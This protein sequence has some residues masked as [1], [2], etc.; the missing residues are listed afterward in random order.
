[1]IGQSIGL[2][3]D[4]GPSRWT[5][6]I[7]DLLAAH[8]AR[9]TFFIVGTAAEAAPGLV[10]RIEAE[11]HEIGNHTWTH[12]ALARDCSD[13]QV[14]D[15]LDRTNELL[16]QILGTRPKLFRAPQ[17][18]CDDRVMG[19]AAELGLRHAHGDVIPPDWLASIKSGVIATLVLQR[20]THGAIVGLHDGIPP[21]EADANLT[22]QPTV[23]AVAVILPALTAREVTCLTVSQVLDG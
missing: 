5:G 12:P 21:S 4:D 22:R 3:F 16:E 10:R 1:M 20:I 11:G 23:D 18:N 14:R 7:L 6:P 13:D 17:Y 2:S 9:A 15:E 19:I 8:R